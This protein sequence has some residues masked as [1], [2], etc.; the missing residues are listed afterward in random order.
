[1]ETFWSSESRVKLAWS[2]PSRDRIGRSQ[3]RIEN[4][5]FL[6]QQEQSDACISYA[7]SRQNCYEVK[8]KN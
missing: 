8:L 4:R 7:E 5:D 1:M 3:L 2:M 6:E